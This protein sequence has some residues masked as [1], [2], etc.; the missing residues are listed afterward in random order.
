M[1]AYPE[2]HDA[3]S[4]GLAT[5]RLLRIAKR[6]RR[7]AHVLHI[8][9]AGKVTLLATHKDVATV[10]CTPQHLTLNSPNFYNQLRP[11]V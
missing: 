2:W 1:R 9:T 6:T 11:F 10:E 3:E 7:R 4:A 5:E 8:T